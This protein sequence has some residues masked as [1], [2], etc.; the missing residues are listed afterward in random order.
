MVFFKSYELFSEV[1]EMT[2]ILYIVNG[3]IS[4]N[5]ELRFGQHLRWGTWTFNQFTVDQDKDDSWRGESLV[6]TVGTY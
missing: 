6:Y 2:R 3:V 1:G 4:Y 5:I